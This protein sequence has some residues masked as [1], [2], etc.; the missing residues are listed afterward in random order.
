[1]TTI[2]KFKTSFVELRK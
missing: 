1:M 2:M